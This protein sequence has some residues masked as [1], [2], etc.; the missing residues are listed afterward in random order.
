MGLKCAL[1]WPDTHI[2]FQNKKACKLA[3]TIAAEIGID[4]LYVLGD[5]ADFYY[6]SGHGPRHPGMLGHLK[7]EV[8]GV[9]SGLD[10]FDRFFPSIPK[11][12]IQGN[13]EF[14]LERYIQNRAPELFGL[15]DCQTLFRIFE[16]PGWRWVS[17]GNN[18]RIQVLNSHLWLRH[19]PLGN[20]A[21][22]TATR[23][24]SS[25]A[26]G[27]CHRIEE[28][29]VVA[30]DGTNHVSFSVGWLGDKRKD[31][32]FG[33]VSGH[34]QWQLGFGLVY[35]DEDTNLF[36]HHKVHILDNMTA[37]VNGKLYRG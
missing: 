7:D 26:Y 21:R 13:H 30:L 31:E 24:L 33:Y 37:V 27:H 35:V 18:Q 23:A 15:I 6:I 25:I 36:Y 1:L 8:D 34:H 20:T 17:Y 16:R 29:H 32:V 14:R 11:F 2:P 10:T 5:L 22:L 28:S 19:E 9:N 12:Y 3:L 4:A